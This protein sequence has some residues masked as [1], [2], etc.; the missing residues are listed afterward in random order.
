MCRYVAQN[1][2]IIVIQVDFRLGPEHP[3]PTQVEDCTS[4][5]KWVRLVMS[6]H[7][8]TVL[9]FGSATQMLSNSV[10]IQIGSSPL[11]HL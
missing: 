2:Q 10:A 11:F 1:A 6:S 3:T 4:A 8:D 7:S 9:T 5:F